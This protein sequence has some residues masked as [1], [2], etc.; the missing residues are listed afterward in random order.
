MLPLHKLKQI[1][2][3]YFRIFLPAELRFSSE[4]EKRLIGLTERTEQKCL[5]G[6]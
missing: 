5:S 6:F 4:K 1:N 3:V 2:A